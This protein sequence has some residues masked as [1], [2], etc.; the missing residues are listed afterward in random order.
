MLAAI[1]AAESGAKVT[2]LEHSKKPGRKLLLT[3]NSRCNLTNTDEEVR[4]LSE[5]I[6]A[7]AALTQNIFPLFGVR[8]TLR[9]FRSIGVLTRCEHGTGV[10]PVSGKSATVSEALLHKMRRL[11]VKLK[12]Q[13]HVTGIE[14]TEGGLIVKTHSW[15][16]PCDAVILSCGSKCAPQTGSDGSGYELAKDLGLSVTQILP[17]LTGISVTYPD[18]SKIRAKTAGIRMMGRVSAYV[19]GDCVQE[20]DGQ[21]QFTDRDL[22]GIAVF[23]LS[24]RLTRALSRGEDCE[25][26]I[27]FLPETGI[28]ELTAALESYAEEW[29]TEKPEELLAGLLP[30][31]IIALILEHPDFGSAAKS[32]SSK[33]RESGQVPDINLM[34]TLAELMK[35][36]RLKPVSVRGFESCQVCAGGV[37]LSEVDPQTLECKRD[38]LRGIYLTGEL[39]DLDG[40][41][42]GYNLQWAFSSGYVAGR[43]A[44]Q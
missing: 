5:D 14:R 8:Q 2:V 22:S 34:R 35:H 12:L 1:S 13:E 44:A 38:D 9:F 11:G 3:G 17:A 28:D 19:S 41:C 36:M 21:L 6:S 18:G 23:Q 10:Y 31:E 20:E 29:Q 26:A 25:V 42:G 43:C 15:Q 16:Y 37:R 32:A 27:D 4:Y 40:P 33:R 39:L 7:A 30:Q 24:R